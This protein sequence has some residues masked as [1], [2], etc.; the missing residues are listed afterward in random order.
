MTDTT[1][2]TLKSIKHLRRDERGRFILVGYFLD[3]TPREYE[4]LNL[5]CESYPTPLR[6]E[7]IVNSFNNLSSDSVTVF[8]NTINK[9]SHIIGGRRLVICHR[10]KGYTLN[11]YM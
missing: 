6:R 8:I 7:D 3:L 4:I 11:E 2:Y 5:I 10:G 9:K 1:A